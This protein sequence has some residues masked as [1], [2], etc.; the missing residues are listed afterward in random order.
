M[1]KHCTHFAFGK[2]GSLISQLFQHA[3]TLRTDACGKTKTCSHWICLLTATLFRNRF[4][5]TLLAIIEYLVIEIR[6]LQPH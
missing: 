2:Q 5:M 3:N 6:T 1:L 4:D